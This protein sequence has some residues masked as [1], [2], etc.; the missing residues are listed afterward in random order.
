VINIILIED[1]PTQAE[2]MQ[3]ILEKK[4]YF[5]HVARSGAEGLALVQTTSKVQAILLDLHLPDM[6]GFAVC[7]KLKEQGVIAPVVLYSQDYGAKE[8]I[9]AYSLGVYYC[10]TKG[11]VNM[12]IRL[13]AIVSIAVKFGKS[14]LAR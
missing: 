14:L 5:V 7:R 3:M 6:D 4:E 13:V 9:E 2:A 10:A 8:M 1:S 12:P 11:D